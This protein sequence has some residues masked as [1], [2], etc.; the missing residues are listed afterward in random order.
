M[1]QEALALQRKDYDAFLAAQY[2]IKVPQ[3]FGTFED[4]K[5]F[6]LD[7]GGSII[8]RTE[9]PTEADGLSGLNYS[10]VITPERVTKDAAKGRLFAN[11]RR[12]DAH[13]FDAIVKKWHETFQHTKHYCQL[14]KLK[15]E[16][17]VAKLQYS[18]WEYVTGF[19]IYVFADPVKPD[20]FHVFSQWPSDDDEH[21]GW[22]VYDLFEGQEI[23]SHGATSPFIGEHFAQITTLYKR[24]QEIFG[25]E[26]CWVVEMQLARTGEL[27]F[28]QRS[29]GPKTTTP[30]WSLAGQPD[31]HWEFK[32]GHAHNFGAVIGATSEAGIETDV[33][34]NRGTRLHWLK[35]NVPTGVLA[36]QIMDAVIEQERL[37]NVAVYIDTRYQ[38]HGESINDPHSSIVPM[39]RA[40]LY[41]YMPKWH[42]LMPPDLA[43][44]ITRIEAAKLPN[45]D[46]PFKWPRD[47]FEN[48]DYMVRLK[49]NIRSDGREAR[50]RV[51]SVC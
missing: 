7:E 33:I 49:L 39:T 21:E 23:L 16:E 14:F 10:H 29:C 46:D 48:P 2:D 40:P 32:V 35:K 27:Y 19:N 51:T 26:V 47:R 11:F 45:K 42:D 43:A 30:T 12:L 20:R 5:R 36:S 6:V 15:P 34:L 37:K 44:E 4:A 31:N 24:V 3:I 50:V 41:L 18:F 1:A 22:A 8:A 9:H 17:Y 28:L 38:S 13:G 25:N